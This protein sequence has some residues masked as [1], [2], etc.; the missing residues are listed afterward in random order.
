MRKKAEFQNITDF[1][2]EFLKISQITSFSYSSQPCLSR[3]W[4]EESLR[5]LCYFHTTQNTY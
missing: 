4:L 2:A 5:R 3:D 1:E